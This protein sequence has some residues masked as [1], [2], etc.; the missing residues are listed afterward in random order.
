ML[1]FS[2]T[3]AFKPT[4]D[5]LLLDCGCS[6]GLL[7]PPVDVIVSSA[8]ASLLPVVTL[9]V[10]TIVVSVSPVLVLMIIVASSVATV[11]KIV[12]VES[13]MLLL[14]LVAVVLIVVL[15]VLQMML[16]TLLQL[17]LICQPRRITELLLLLWLH[18]GRLLLLLLL[19][20]L[21]LL[22]LSVSHAGVVEVMHGR[23]DVTHM[24]SI[25]GHGLRLLLVVHRRPLASKH[26]LSLDI[27]QSLHARHCGRG[28][29]GSV[30][31]LLELWRLLTHELRLLMLMTS[32]RHELR[33]VGRR[34]FGQ[35]HDGGV[36]EL[37]RGWALGKVRGGQQRKLLG[38]SRLRLGHQSRLLLLH[39]LLGRELMMVDHLLLLGKVLRHGMT[40]THLTSGGLNSERG[41]GEAS[42]L[43]TQ[44]VHPLHHVC[45]TLGS[46]MSGLKSVLKLPAEFLT[47]GG[48]VEEV[49]ALLE[50]HPLLLRELGELLVSV[51][52][53]LVTEASSSESVIVESVQVVLR[54]V[55][56][57]TVPLNALDQAVITHG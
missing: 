38:L 30:L 24:A 35:R 33:L 48:K 19:M 18:L 27:S 39:H 3:S 14:L 47:V 34:Q 40:L 32:P 13:L 25:H 7:V 37:T 4:F 22:G 54:P 43:Q 17:L 57:F 12:V 52:L 28:E 49:L 42:S 8:P 53:P 2:K 9:L 41:R 31:L 1:S 50:R 21:M 29:G 20:H 56:V 26:H 46:V 5:L 15:V 23:V 10:I 6:E 36:L 45:A 16:K 11:M 55:V 51:L 44:L